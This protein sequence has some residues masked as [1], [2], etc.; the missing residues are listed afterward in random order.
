MI[1]GRA[2]VALAAVSAFATGMSGTVFAASST[3]E[4][5]KKVVSL[6]GILNTGSYEAA[7]TREE[8]ARM[9]VNASEYRASAK[10]VSN[11]SVFSDVNRE[12]EYAYDIRIAA[13]NGWM[14]GYLGG[15]FK[16]Q[17]PVSM[18]DAVKAVLAV[19]GYENSDFSGN[20]QENRMA[21]FSNLSLDSNI[22]RE[23]DELLTKEDCINLFYNLMKAKSKSGS[24]YGSSVFDLTYNT[25]GEVNT[26]SILDNSLKGPKIL[27]Q[28]SRNLKSLVPFSL[29]KAT[30]FLN[31]ESSDASEIND[32]ATV[33]YYHEATKTIFA[34]SDGGENK[35]ATEGRIKAIYYSS[36]DPFT[37]T[38]VVLDSYNQDNEDGDGDTFVLKDSELQYLFSVYG[39]FK[40]GDDVAIVWEKSGTDENATYTAVD[41]VGDY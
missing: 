15:V 27:N 11:V 18:K 36:T 2:V 38:T 14:S 16:P 13:Q 29:D 1:R 8:F 3:L 37:P 32:Y 9:L 40:V 33:I 10:S 21:R 28:S 6:L 35:G 24:Q 25:D 20:L 4:M 34:Y 17:E 5:R 23:A 19:L 41:V 30:M 26:S 7:V 31:G 22:Y 12:S 39:D